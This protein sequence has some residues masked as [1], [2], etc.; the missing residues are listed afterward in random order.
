MA[1]RAVI[2]VITVMAVR[3]VITVIT[4][5]AVRAV[6]TVIT[7]RAVMAGLG[8]AIHDFVATGQVV[9]AKRNHN[10]G[11]V[12]HIGAVNAVPHARAS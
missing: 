8:P 5:M 9:G 11:A 7:V 1:V 2:T 12:A 10:R 6:I 3:A 4:V